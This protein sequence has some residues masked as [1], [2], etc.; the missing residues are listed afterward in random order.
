[1]FQGWIFDSNET[2][3]LPLTKQALDFC[4]QTDEEMMMTGCPSS[5]SRFKHG[6][7]YTDTTKLEKLKHIAFPYGGDKPWQRPKKRSKRNN[8]GSHSSN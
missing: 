6:T 8:T 1:M 5:F 7:I 4:T 2:N 3:A